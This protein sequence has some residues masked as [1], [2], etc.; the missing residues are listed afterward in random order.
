MFIYRK[1]KLEKERIEKLPGS[2][3]LRELLIET[4]SD[5]PDTIDDISYYNKYYDLLVKEVEKR[6]K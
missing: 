6:L 5:G 1:I 3:L 4:R 2:K